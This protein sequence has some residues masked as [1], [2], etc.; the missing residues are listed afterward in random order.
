MNPLKDVLVPEILAHPQ[1]TDKTVRLLGFNR[2][3][4]TDF[5]LGDYDPTFE[6]VYNIVRFLGWT[7]ADLEKKL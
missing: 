4:W 6:Q 1:Y 3:Q 5:C 7:F 2:R